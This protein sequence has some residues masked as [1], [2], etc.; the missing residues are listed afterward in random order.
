MAQAPLRRSRLA[1]LWL[2]TLTLA[3]GW[4]LPAGAPWLSTP[5]PPTA[6]LLRAPAPDLL[7]VPPQLPGGDSPPGGQMTTPY[8][9][10][11]MVFID[12]TW[13]YYSIHGR[14]LG[15]PVTEM[16]GK[17][18]EL[19]H[20]F[21]FDRLPYLISHHLHT[22][23]LQRHNAYRFVEVAR[24]MVFTSARADTHRMSNRLRMFRD[25]EGANYEVHMTT[26]EG[27]QEK[28]VDISLAVEMMHYAGMDGAY[29][30]AVL[31]S[32]DK[33]FMP[34]LS[35]VRYRG[36][37]VALC[38]MRNCCSRDLTDPSA[39]VRDFEPIWLDDYLDFLI[40]PYD[41]A[42]GATAAEGPE[43]T[44]AA[45]ELD[46]ESDGFADGDESSPGGGDEDAEG[47]AADEDED[48]A[49]AGLEWAKQ[50]EE[51]ATLEISEMPPL[52]IED[53]IAAVE[54][55]EARARL[56][57]VE[58]KAAKAKAADRAAVDKAAAAEN[59]TPD[60]TPPGA[61]A[62]RAAARTAARDAARTA[63]RAAA[64]ARIPPP[65]LNGAATS[66]PRPEPRRRSVQQP[67]PGRPANLGDARPSDF[68]G[69]GGGDDDDGEGEER[70]AE[71]RSCVAD[72]LAASGGQESSRNVGRHLAAKGLLAP[73]KARHAGLFHF[74]QQTP[75]LFRVELPTATGGTSKAQRGLEYQ[76]ILGPPTAAAGAGAAGRD[77]GDAA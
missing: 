74:L 45:A 67:A 32:G 57:E 23:L 35:R 75:D 21:A 7:Q 59:A 76:V 18:W 3:R 56:A 51:G 41:N 15:C 63:A 29:D 55:A 49:A 20:G 65:P 42:A 43:T 68:G 71:L 40:A 34:A 53:E 16:Y 36:K 50:L 33:D 12:G 8:P 62:A 30:I 24:T 44:A 46:E 5:P 37:Q 77:A 9:V 72:F 38:S 69:G 4:R 28:C 2:T 6:S 17:G 10:K 64:P 1:V 39:H 22:Q 11:V 13:L 26:T 47:D 60:A 52:G 73:L 70:D 19:S 31:L 66:M 25:M 14:R 48:E 61:S 27:H 54:A 58:R